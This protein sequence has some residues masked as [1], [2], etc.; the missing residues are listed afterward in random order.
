MLIEPVG[1]LLVAFHDVSSLGAWHYDL[2]HVQ[3]V[4]IIFLLLGTCTLFIVIIIIMAIYLFYVD[5]VG[6]PRR[7]FVDLFFFVMIIGGLFELIFYAS[8][9]VKDDDL[10]RW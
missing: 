3:W 10:R 8:L 5:L 1:L 7:G 6:Q 2:G 4:D 9:G